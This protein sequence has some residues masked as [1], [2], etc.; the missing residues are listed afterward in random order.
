MTGRQKWSIFNNLFV[1][2]CFV[3]IVVE[4][5]LFAG[6]NPSFLGMHNFLFYNTHRIVFHP[7]LLQ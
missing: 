5:G 6:Q 4:K 3:E 1:A 2:A 7:A